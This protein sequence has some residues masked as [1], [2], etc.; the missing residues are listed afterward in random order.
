MPISQIELET[1]PPTLK[2]FMN[3]WND[4]FLK[5]LVTLLLNFLGLVFGRWGRVNIFVGRRLY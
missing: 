5:S 3:D 4:P 1:I 2:G